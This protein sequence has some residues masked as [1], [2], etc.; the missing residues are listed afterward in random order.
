MSAPETEQEYLERAKQAVE[1][2]EVEGGTAILR[3]I[4]RTQEMY[5]PEGYGHARREVD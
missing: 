1:D 3:F 2:M 5:F 4:Q